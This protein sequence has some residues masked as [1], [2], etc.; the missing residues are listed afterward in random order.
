VTREIAYPSDA[1]LTKQILQACI[2]LLDRS[3]Q[4]VVKN[5]L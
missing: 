2:R 1:H 5:S 4:N 3:C